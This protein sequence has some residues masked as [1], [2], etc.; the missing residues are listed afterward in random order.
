ML[1][2]VKIYKEE[3]FLPTKRCRKIRTQL[4]EDYVEVNV[5]EIISAKEFP[6]AFIVHDYKSVYEGAKSYS[7]FDGNGEYK[8]FSEEIRTFNGFLYKPVRVTHGSAISTCFETLDYIKHRLQDD[9]PYWRGNNEFTEESVVV[10]SNIE[11]RKIELIDKS[12]KFIIFDNIPWERCGEPM[13]VINTFGLG[14]NHGGT[15][16]FVTYCYNSNISYKNYFNA[17]QRKEA[18][19]YGKHTALNRGDTNSV[20]NI[21]KYDIIEVMMPEMVTRNPKKE[22]GDG[23]D[24]INGVERMIS[25]TKSDI[26]AAIMLGAMCACEM[27]RRN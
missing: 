26:E 24:F 23:D 19:E 17:L 7:D 12:N 25:G 16:F 6:V 5:K 3:K 13:Y 20:E 14:H 21:G 9:I 10:E 22:H 2:N 4:V 11:E 1:M 27:N 15:G 8:M 18:I